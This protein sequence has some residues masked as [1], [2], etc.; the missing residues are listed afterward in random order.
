MKKRVSSEFRALSIANIYT[1]S[2][3]KLFFE[4]SYIEFS[5]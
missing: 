3:R 4:D 2:S 1:F 5:W